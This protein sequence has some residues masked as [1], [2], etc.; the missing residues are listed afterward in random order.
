[1]SENNLDGAL[2]AW[3]FIGCLAT[4]CLYLRGCVCGQVWRNAAGLFR[5]VPSQPCADLHRGALGNLHNRFGISFSV[6]QW[7]SPPICQRGA[8]VFLDHISSTTPPHPPRLPSPLSFSQP[9]AHTLPYLSKSA[10]VSKKGG[11]K[12]RGRRKQVKPFPSLPPLRLF[13]EYQRRARR[14]Y[15]CGREKNG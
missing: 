4:A 3:I 2:R 11:K 1:M 15:P 12:R 5:F 13:C 8:L 14:L 10:F 9:P 7:P 6:L